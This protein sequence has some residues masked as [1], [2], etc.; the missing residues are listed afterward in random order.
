MKHFSLYVLVLI[1]STI[2]H[3]MVWALPE[4][5]PEEVLRTEIILEA[6]SPIDGEPLSAEE[7]IIIQDQIA[8]NDVEIEIKPEIKKLVF[9]LRLRKLLKSLTPF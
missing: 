1:L 4:D 7:Y 9:L 6:R 3:R 2:D 5:Q 8:Q